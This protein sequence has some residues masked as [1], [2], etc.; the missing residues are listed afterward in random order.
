MRC[1]NKSDIERMGE[2]NQILDCSKVIS[3][4][5]HDQLISQFLLFFLL[6]ILTCICLTKN[7]T[8]YTKK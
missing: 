8:H 7:L 1:S 3:G 6:F 4:Y 2:K 5:F